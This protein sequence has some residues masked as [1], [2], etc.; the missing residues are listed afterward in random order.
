[1]E[2]ADALRSRLLK[3]GWTREEIDKTI[4]MLHG[5]G[6]QE[7]HIFFKKEL[8]ITLYW[9][10]LLLLTVCN[11]LISIVLIPFLIV[12]NPFQLDITVAVL[13]VIFGL[14]FNHIIRDIEHIEAKHHLIAA[15]FI[16][17][18]AL[19]N[20]FLMVSVANSF[21]EKFE[22]AKQHNPVFTSIIYVAAF[23]APYI[24]GILRQ[25]REK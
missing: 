23:L 21:A 9:T 15:I 5:E 25:A 14:F 16:P 18:V 12:T 13:G 6:K 24:I 19:I 10:T 17:A 11:F 1:M 2:D 22:F 3:K 20:V 8:N 4:N 7:K